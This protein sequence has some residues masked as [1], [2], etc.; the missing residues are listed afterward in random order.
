MVLLLYLIP[1]VVTPVPVAAW[2]NNGHVKTFPTNDLLQRPTT[3]PQ[4]TNANFD[5]LGSWHRSPNVLR[6]NFSLKTP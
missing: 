1:T 4:C 2:L 5:R 3:K 6:A